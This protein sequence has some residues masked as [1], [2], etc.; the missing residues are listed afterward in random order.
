M[1]IYACVLNPQRN[2]LVMLK[3]DDTD[4]ADTEW[5]QQDGVSFSY[6]MHIEIKAAGMKVNSTTIHVSTQSDNTVSYHRYNTSTDV[7]D[8]RGETV[9]GSLSAP[10]FVSTDVSFGTGNGRTDNDPIVIYKVSS[11]TVDYSSKTGSTWTDRT[12]LSAGSEGG[13]ALGPPD[14][15]DRCMGVYSDSSVNDVLAR[16]ILSGDTLGTEDTIDASGD[17]ADSI[18][19]NVVID[20]A[21]IP[22]V[23]YLDSTN[24]AWLGDAQ[25]AA[26]SP[27]WTNSGASISITSAVKGHGRTSPPYACM[28]MAVKTDEL[29]LIWIESDVAQDMF[30]YA[31]LGAKILP[32]VPPPVPSALNTTI[33]KKGWAIVTIVVIFRLTLDAPPGKSRVA[34]PLKSLFEAT[35]VG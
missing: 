31:D 9:R 28:F 5:T 11:G 2:G 18:I 14:G 7:W 22:Y 15:S 17:T 13:C 10:P 33:A 30:H 34:N 26:D 29:H 23:P 3:A 1:A 6:P 20:S 19:G 25:T 21:G 16:N 27:T 32:N 35:N 12:A 24:H 4:P 8:I